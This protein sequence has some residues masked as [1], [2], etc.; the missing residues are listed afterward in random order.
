MRPVILIT[1][2]SGFTGVHAC[3]YY[4]QSGMR[5]VAVSRSPHEA[6]LAA[7]EV[8]ACDLTDRRRVEKLVWAV[9][10]DLVLHL[11]GMNDV[12]SSWADPIDCL[13]INVT[14]TIH[15]LGAAAA[16]ANK[17]TVLVVGS[18][19]SFQPGT[20]AP[21]PTHPYSLSKTL[22]TLTARA[23]AHLFQ[24][25]VTAAE[26]TNLIGP[27]SSS[28][29]CGLLADYLARWE[30]GLASEPFRISS[31][32]EKR[33]YLDVRDAVAA[34]DKI[35]RHGTPGELYRFG[36]PQ[37][38]S[39]GE[40]LQTFTAVI[41]TP[42]PYVNLDVAPRDPDPMAPAN[43]TVARLGWMPL[44]PF[45]HSIRDMLEDARARLKSQ[46]NGPLLRRPDNMARNAISPVSHPSDDKEGA[47]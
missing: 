29:L 12:K 18:S 40:V 14:G 10:P 9:Q 38:R 4:H 6:D 5:V 44:I 1:G 17:P 25:P 31:L 39:I 33:S 45:E 19:L 8:V 37:L 3:S 2:A 27:G 16:L 21:K 47:S 46:L 22:Q 35:L 23:W 42:F 43:V 34:Y 20:D 11:A 41:G 26:P 30:Q 7:D 15:L 28:G 24:L 13:N 32:T 36:S